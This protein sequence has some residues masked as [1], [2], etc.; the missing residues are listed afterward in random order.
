MLNQFRNLL[1]VSSILSTTLSFGADATLT[2]HKKKKVKA[3]ATKEVQ[4][5]EAPLYK[6]EPIQNEEGYLKYFSPVGNTN[7]YFG[8][9]LSNSV[10]LNTSVNNSSA[11]YIAEGGLKSPGM[12][13]GVECLPIKAYDFR[14]GMG[15]MYE[16]QRSFDTLSETTNSAITITSGN[17][18]ELLKVSTLSALLQ[19]DLVN[20]F[21]VIAGLNINFVSLS[22]SPI[23]N[24]DTKSN[25]GLQLAGAYTYNNI[26]AQLLYKTVSGN[27]TGTSKYYNTGVNYTGTY[28]YNHLALTVGLLF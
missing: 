8:L 20:N 27:V 7:V 25:F 13:F 26:R 10:S 3:V 19:R 21:S 17:R 12:A 5:K 14:F 23:Y 2:N 24:W 22:E 11:T 28:N 18:T 9:S 15:F 16:F 6:N 4:K 1:L